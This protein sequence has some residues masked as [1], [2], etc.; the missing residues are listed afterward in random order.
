MIKTKFKRWHCD[1]SYGKHVQVRLL[2]KQGMSANKD[3]SLFTEILHKLVAL[4][5]I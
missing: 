3:I 2:L 5:K 4:C 1:Y